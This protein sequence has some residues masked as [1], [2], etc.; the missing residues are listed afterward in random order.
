M[1]TTHDKTLVNRYW[2]R[3]RLEWGKKYWESGTQIR[4][5]KSVIAGVSRERRLGPPETVYVKGLYRTN[6]VAA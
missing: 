5:D 3:R 2:W 4:G 1:A 6:F